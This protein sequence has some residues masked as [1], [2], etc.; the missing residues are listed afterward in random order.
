ME[1][2]SQEEQGGIT[3]ITPALVKEQR[4][5]AAWGQTPRHWAELGSQ[6]QARDKWGTLQDPRESRCPQLSLYIRPTLLFPG[7]IALRQE[8]MVLN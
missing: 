1:P 7:Q 5:A 6:T 2:A 8:E 3:A 4:G